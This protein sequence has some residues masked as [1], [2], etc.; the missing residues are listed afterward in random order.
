MQ[1]GN[2]VSDP[3]WHETYK[4]KSRKKVVDWRV[5]MDE[6]IASLTKAHDDA[7]Y[8]LDWCIANYRDQ[9]AFTLLNAALVINLVKAY[10]QASS[11]RL[12]A[13]PVRDNRETML[14]YKSDEVRRLGYRLRGTVA[15]ILKRVA[16]Y[17]AQAGV[18][19]VAETFFQA[20]FDAGSNAP[21]LLPFRAA[22]LLRQNK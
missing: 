22:A 21:D 15:F 1:N 2:L 4:S 6:S 7:T 20:A 19:D 18:L 9:H 14:W 13:G 10:Y 8:G 17:L 12:P 11:V 5:L 3:A 16:T